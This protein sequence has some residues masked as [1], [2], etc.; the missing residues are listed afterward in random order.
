MHGK[1]IL[2]LTV[3][4]FITIFPGGAQEPLLE[5]SRPAI[6]QI[7]HQY[8]LQHPEVLMESVRL[9]QERERAAQKERSKEAISAR[10]KDVQQDPSSPVAGPAD[11]VTVVEFFDYHCGYCKRAEPTVMKLLAE[12][13]DVRFIFKEFPIL[14]PESSLAAK[15]GLA[16]AKQG[17]YLKFHQALMALSGSITMNAIE[18]LAGKQGLDVSKLKGDM[19]SPE[20]QSILTRNRELGIKLGVNATPTFVVGSELIAG[21]IDTATFERLIAQPKASSAPRAGINSR[22]E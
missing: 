18:E 21:A 22:K 12:H 2:R 15:A 4:G 10:L 1:F 9:Y 19:E 5:T 17:A 20:V 3:F 7:V 8:I 6:E 16:A 14:G 11:G 13:P